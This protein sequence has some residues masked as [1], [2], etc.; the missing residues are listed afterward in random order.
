MDKGN[1]RRRLKLDGKAETIGRKIWDPFDRTNDLEIHWRLFS[2]SHCKLLTKCII[3]QRKPLTL[4][5]IYTVYIHMVHYT[6]RCEQIVGF[7]TMETPPVLRFALPVPPAS[8][9]L[10]LVLRRFP[11]VECHWWCVVTGM[12]LVMVGPRMVA[13]LWYECTALRM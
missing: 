11:N 9:F 10:N 6:Y 13:M 4:R 2:L 12:L 7:Y 5:D 8:L 1:T 3:L